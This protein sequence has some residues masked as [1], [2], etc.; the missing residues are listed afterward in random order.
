MDSEKAYDRIHQEALWNVPEIYGVGG[1]L[2]EGM[3]PFY[4]EGSVLLR[5]EREF[6]GSFA[7]QAG[8][9]QGYTMSP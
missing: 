5:V 9:R 6:C 4:K 7:I 1:Q 8:V 3:K 2:L